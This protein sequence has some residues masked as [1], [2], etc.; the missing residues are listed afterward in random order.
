[1]KFCANYCV[2]LAYV[3]TRRMGDFP[4]PSFAVQIERKLRKRILD[5]CGKEE[6]VALLDIDFLNE[7]GL[8]SLPSDVD[9]LASYFRQKQVD[10]LFIPHVNF[11][12]EEAVALLAKKLNVPVLLWGPRDTTFPERMTDS[13]CGMFATSMALQRCRVPFTYIENC[14]MD[15]PALERGLSKFIRV[16]SVVKAFRNLRI[17][18]ISMRPQNF[19]SVRYNENELMEK[20]GIE[21]VAVDTIE[22]KNTYDLYFK[23]RPELVETRLAEYAHVDTAAMNSQRLRRSIALELALEHIAVAHNCNGMACQCFELFEPMLDIWPC[24][25]FANLTQRGLP[26]ACETDVLGAITSVL[27]QAAVRNNGTTFLT[28]LT[29]RHPT[30]SNAELLWHCGVF[31]TSLAKDGKGNMRSMCIGEYE[32]KPGHLTLARLGGMDGKYSLFADEAS[33]TAG[34]ETDST[35]V[36]AKMDNWPKWEEK[37]I[38][39]PYIHHVSGAYGEY[40]EILHEACKYLE[41]ISADYIQ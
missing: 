36:W 34:P 40:A 7:E 19:L 17:A 11:G 39:G 9:T 23:E 27:L 32:L 8:L 14:S 33:T 12:S 28:D 25:A 22:L 38:Y 3:P 35:Y 18:Q 10:A 37:F 4:D 1:M 5:I 20:F 41:G 16:S 2:K 15:D 30:D 31:P 29:V 24:Q 6:N 26:V 13:Q 21:I